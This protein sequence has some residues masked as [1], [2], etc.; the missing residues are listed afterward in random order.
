MAGL[1]EA[2]ARVTSIE[3]GE[4]CRSRTTRLSHSYLSPP[5]R[6]SITF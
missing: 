5:A 6:S 3:R 2:E 4:I 1:F